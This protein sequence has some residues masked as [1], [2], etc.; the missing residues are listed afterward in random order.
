MP[1]KDTITLRVK[2]ILRDQL[3][4]EV[5]E[6]N[7][8]I[9]EDLGMDS[10]SALEVIYDLKEEFSIEINEKDFINIKTVKDLTGYV[11]DK[12]DKKKSLT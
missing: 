3:N 8:L 7:S 6:D 12:A 10:F 11:A 4:I 9:R 1:G 2:E 5:L